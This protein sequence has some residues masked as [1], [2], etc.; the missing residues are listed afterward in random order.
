[1]KALLLSAVLMFGDVMPI[2]TL[3]DLPRDVWIQLDTR[4]GAHIEGFLI[5]STAQRVVIESGDLRY[6]VRPEAIDVVSVNRN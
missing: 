6:Y 2:A 3:V 5:D 1:M 4:G